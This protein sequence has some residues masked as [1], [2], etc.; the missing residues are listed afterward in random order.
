MASETPTLAPTG[1]ARKHTT[2]PIVTGTSIIAVKY[3]DGILVGGDTLGSYG[4]LARFRD[5][6]RIRA[7][8][9]S[10]LIAAGGEYSD[11]QYL[12]DMLDDKVVDELCKDDGATLDASEYHSFLTRVMYQRRNKGNPLYNNLIVAGYSGGSGADGGKPFLGTIDPIATAY[13]DDFLVT[14]F[15]AHLALPIIR[16]RWTAGMSEAEARTLVEDCLRVC[17]YRD[18]RTINKVQL[19]KVTRDGVVV[20]EP[21]ELDTEW[22]FQSFIDPKAGAEFGGSW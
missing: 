12:V 13:T 5:L 11:F 16:E 18:C 6:R 4:S 19:G 22:S 1:D 15:G 7:V 14:G 21:F 2:S 9:K 10:T 8:G 20:S 17:Y 3:A